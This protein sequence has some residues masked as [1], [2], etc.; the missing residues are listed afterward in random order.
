MRKSILLLS[1]IALVAFPLWAEDE[2]SLDA[3]VKEL[4]AKVE[5]LDYDLDQVR[6]SS[7]DALFW[8]RLSDVAEVDKVLLAGP[9]NPRAEEIYGIKNERHPLRIYLYVFLPKQLDRAKKRPA[10]VRAR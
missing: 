4:A 7:D 10:I 1:L 3:R 9:P 2:K 8:L 6:K 5:S